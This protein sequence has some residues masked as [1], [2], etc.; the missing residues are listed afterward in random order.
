[1][2]DKT[3]LL[4]SAPILQFSSADSW[5]LW[6]GSKASK[7]RSSERRGTVIKV[8]G[9][10]TGLLM[11]AGSFALL[12]WQN[13]FFPVSMGLA[14]GGTLLSILSCFQLPRSEQ[15]GHRRIFKTVQDS[16]QAEQLSTLLKTA[17]FR[18]F[19]RATYSTSE[20]I[21]PSELVMF[22]IVRESTSRVMEALISTFTSGSSHPD[23]KPL[24]DKVCDLVAREWSEL[25]RTRICKEVPH[26]DIQ[27]LIV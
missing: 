13:R 10:T 27:A 21:L 8:A 4:E 22:N 26:R 18:A 2:L 19:L 6:A 24:T 9:I 16:M 17:D 20:R 5:Q 11:A 7:I 3:P 25:Q 1:M 14:M 15:I 23:C 12:P